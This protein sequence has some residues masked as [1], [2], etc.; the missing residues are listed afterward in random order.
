MAGREKSWE[1][2]HVRRGK[3]MKRK[4]EKF[5]KYGSDRRKLNF[6]PLQGRRKLKRKPLQRWNEDKDRADEVSRNQ[7]LS[8]NGGGQKKRIEP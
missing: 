3:P 1:L 6:E 5:S 7:N 8:R 4:F 2:M